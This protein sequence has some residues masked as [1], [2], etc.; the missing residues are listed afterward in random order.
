MSDHERVGAQIRRPPSVPVLHW[1]DLFRRA[2]SESWEDLSGTHRL[3]YTYSGR[4]ALYQ[5]FAGL[6]R[7]ATHPSRNVVLV[8]AFHCP[9]VVDPILHA[10]YQ[11]RFYAIDERLRIDAG[12]F[13]NKLDASVVAA[14]FIRYFG[15]GSPDRELVTACRA[16]DVRIVEDCCHSFLA[17]NPLRPTY[18]GA[19]ATVYAFWKLVP[20]LAGGGLMLPGDAHF[21]PATRLTRPLVA[22]S[23]N[24]IGTLA[25]QLLAREIDLVR[26]VFG[27]DTSV[28]AQQAEK[29][30]VRK[31]AA[32][33]YPYDPAV[34]EWAM[35]RTA[36]W[37]LA[38][39]RLAEISAARRRN[40]QLLSA[41]L[42]FTEEIVAVRRE[43]QGDT[44]PWGFPVL[45][46]RRQ[47]RDYLIRARGV[48]LFTFGEVLH[49]HLFA[50]KA[51]N[52]RM[53]ETARRLS[54]SILVFSV[55]QD[56]TVVQMELFA[57][58]INAFI[59]GH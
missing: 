42:E 23:Y 8:P 22:D 17:V 39:A 5:Y 51:L 31:P 35:P 11:V 29:P 50:R 15:F 20:S 49:P 53:L 37:I 19:D 36:W 25:R 45:L 44:C 38:R 6:Q 32:Q 2:P 12:D 33:A 43:L 27:S 10:G 47:E 48:P 24:R 13:L 4:A 57:A 41:R 14:L 52:S 30:S 16:A 54:D 1:A 59:A 34:S 28:A 26:G 18:S 9:T 55:H 46:G 21:E 3:H 56:L 7:T 40:Y 58:I